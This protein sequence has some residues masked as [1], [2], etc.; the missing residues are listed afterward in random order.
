MLIQGTGAV[1]AGIWARS[2]CV[3]QGL[4]QGSVFPMLDFA[5]ATGQSVIVLN[6]NMK[7]DP[8]TQQEIAYCSTMVEHCKFVWE[9][10]ITRERCAAQT[11]SIVA[12]SAGGRCLASLFQDYQ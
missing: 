4:V 6:P 7:L 11:L 3:D 9:N 2:V 12:H 8:Y 1:R 5:K 10:F